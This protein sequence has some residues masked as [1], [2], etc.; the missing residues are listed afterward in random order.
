MPNPA[1]VS[2]KNRTTVRFDALQLGALRFGVQV[3]SRLA[4]GWLEAEAARLFLTPRRPANCPEPQLAGGVRPLRR[5]MASG[6]YR[7]SFYIWGRG[8][9]VLLVHGWEGR[10]SQLT[11]FAERIVGR[12]FQAVAVDLP[13]HGRSSGKEASLPAFVQAILDLSRDV[14]PFKAVIAHSLGAAATGFVATEQ[15]LA[16]RLVLIA[17]AAEPRFFSQR[18]AH[19]LGLPPSRVPGMNR[20]IELR[21]GRA[22]DE[23]DLG[24]RAG[25]V[26]VPLLVLHDEGDRE[27][28]LAHG[29]TVAALSRQGRLEV[30]RGL[31]HRRILRAP[32]IVARAVD[33][34][35]S[36]ED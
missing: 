24:L 5:Q 15:D 23:F 18:A 20:Q 12:G 10:A 36:S 6:P 8:E 9:P 13:A 30:V 29:Q 35:L 27:V 22:L 25:R 33:F 4:P 16:G 11:P 26:D 14:G 7:L 19:F 34:A 3:A 28:P 2:V 1:F 21:L 31:G 32:E 17:P